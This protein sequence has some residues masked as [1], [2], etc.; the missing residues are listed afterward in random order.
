M[1]KFI[2]DY[3]P[4]IIIT[5]AVIILVILISIITVENT[6]GSNE[7][8]YNAYIILDDISKLSFVDN[9][10]I[11]IDN[12]DRYYF[13]ID[14]KRNYDISHILLSNVAEL[15]YYCKSSKEFNDKA[16]ELYEQLNKIRRE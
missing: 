12:S 11:C 6:N 16:L 3:S 9:I 2:E 14:L 13:T 8:K 4:V 7:Y 10:Y 15:K 1:K 5:L